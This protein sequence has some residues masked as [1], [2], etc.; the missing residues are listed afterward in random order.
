MSASVQTG[1]DVQPSRLSGPA[2]RPLTGPWAWR[3]NDL[4]GDQ[5]WQF[6]WSEAEIEEMLAQARSAVA[7]GLDYHAMLKQPLDLPLVAA[8][9]ALVHAELEGG[10]GL[11][12][13]RGLPVGELERDALELLWMALARRLGRPV[14]QDLNGQSLRLIRDEGEVVGARYGQIE[15]A[16]KGASFLSSRARTASTGALRFHTDRTDVVGLLCNGVSRSGG[17]SKIASSVAVH[18]EMLAQRPDLA[19]LL[20][21]PIWR[22]RLGEERDGEHKAYPLPVFGLRQG[23]FTSHYSRTYVEA[24]QLNPGVPVMTQAQWE[25]LDLLAEIAE[26]LCLDT[27][28][29]VGDIQLLNSHVTYHART[30]FENDPS[31]GHVRSLYRIW[32]CT[33]PHHR[34]LPEDHRVLW[35]AVE[36]GTFRGGI[37]PDPLPANG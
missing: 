32:L 21:Q 35:Q 29:G 22:S 34:P 10:C 30:A 33:A 18:N 31:A 19:Q 3:G 14:S 4:A 16:A 7:R 15:D 20:Y 1:Q 5:R 26:S 6:H 27:Q 24:A 36:K 37:R 25:A 13:L 28:L 17:L 2:P 11:V 23:Y 9:L 12:L 8:K